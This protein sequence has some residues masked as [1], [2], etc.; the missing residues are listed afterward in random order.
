MHLSLPRPSIEHTDALL[1]MPQTRV[2]HYT[3][4]A[5]KVFLIT[6]KKNKKVTISILI[7][8]RLNSKNLQN[9]NKRTSKLIILYFLYLSYQTNRNIG[10][11]SSYLQVLD[12]TLRIANI[13]IDSSEALL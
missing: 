3:N 6:I 12:I 13:V 7:I 5:Y 11:I 2:K 8:T 1:V 4:K 10:N 9:Y